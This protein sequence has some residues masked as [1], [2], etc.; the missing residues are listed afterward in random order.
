MKDELKKPWEKAVLPLNETIGQAVRVLNETGLKIILVINSQNEFQGTISDGDI[1]R[2][3]L[4]GLDFNSPID[5]VTHRNALVAPLEMGRKMILQLMAINK[6][7]QIPVIDDCQRVVGLHTWDEISVHQ[8]R[9]NIFVIM[10]GGRGKRLNPQTENCP[11]PLLIVQG[12]P[13]L[14]HII[15]RAKIEGFRNFVISL[16]YLGEMIEDYFGNGEKF[17]ISIKYLKEPF[18]MGTAGA[19][20]LLSPIPEIPFIVTN[21]DVISDIQYGDFLDFHINNGAD[22]TMAVKLYEWQNPFG[23]IQTDGFRIVGYEE[24]PITQTKINAGVYILEPHAVGLLE[25]TKFCDMPT[26]FERLRENSAK[27]AAYPLHENWVD[28]GQPDDLSRLREGDNLE[29]SR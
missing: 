8:D 26:L 4:K 12:K 16:K 7:Q 3:L 29:G 10:A 18:P 11:K 13:I 1:R 20:S 23:V 14:E 19:L 5:E 6:I 22:A 2:G 28:V 25:P 15:E 27:L 17:G 24:K 9:D 21:G